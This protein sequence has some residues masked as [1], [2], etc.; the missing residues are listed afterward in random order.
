MYML[1]LTNWAM[2]TLMEL[3]AQGEREKTTSFPATSIITVF[4]PPLCIYSYFRPGFRLEQEWSWVPM[5][6]TTARSNVTSTKTT[7]TVAAR[8]HGFQP[9]N[10][11]P[12][13]YTQGMIQFPLVKLVP[14]ETGE[15]QMGETIMYWWIKGVLSALIS[16]RPFSKQM[17]ALTHCQCW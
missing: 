7:T 14:D 16:R 8:A 3:H 11:S 17:K 12:R 10:L 15:V 2:A 5:G 4:P 9:Q 1:E 6:M 13:L